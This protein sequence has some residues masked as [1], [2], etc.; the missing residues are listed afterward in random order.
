MHKTVKILKESNIVKSI[1]S[2]DSDA[3]GDYYRLKIQARLINGWKLNVWE[4][5]TPVFIRYAYHIS[6]GSELII[7]W[8]NA[9]HHKQIKTFPH[10]KHVGETILESNEM[11]IKVILRE[12]EKMINDDI[13]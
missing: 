1:I 2:I 5:A 10:H 11:E 4:H 6:K 8:D 12:L 7:R 13:S 9:P 3:Y